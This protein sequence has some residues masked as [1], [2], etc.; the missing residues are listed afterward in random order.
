MIYTVRCTEKRPMTNFQIVVNTHWQQFKLLKI[1]IQQKKKVKESLS[2]S[3]SYLSGQNSCVPTEK[4]ETNI[5]IKTVSSSSS[6]THFQFLLTLDWIYTVHSVQGSSLE[7]GAIDF[8]V[9]QKFIYFRQLK[10]ILF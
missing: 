1:K 6:I 8:D 4:C 10:E 7:Q 3:S 9:R 5:S 2:L